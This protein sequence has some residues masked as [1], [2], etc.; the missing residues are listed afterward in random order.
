MVDPQT[1][2]VPPGG[3]PILNY[4]YRNRY[5][6]GDYERSAELHRRLQPDLLISGHWP[7]QQVTDEYLDRLE[8]DGRR[9]DELHRELLPVE[10]DFG[11]E[12]FGA[13]IEPYRSSVRSGD[14]LELD[15]VVRNPF[16][17]PERAAVRLVVPAGWPDP[18]PQELELPPLGHDVVRFTVILDG[19]APVARARVAA[20]LTVGGTM[21]GQ[22]AEAL[23][24]VE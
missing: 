4:Q 2:G 3:R 5:R 10:A 16:D 8:E 15:V 6:V 11:A 21:F 20:D 23:V 17:R 9:L 22:Q 7:P 18:E 13:R 1:T 12:G 14:A 24:D 19:V